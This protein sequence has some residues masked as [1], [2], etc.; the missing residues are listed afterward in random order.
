MWNSNLVP[1]DRVRVIM[2]GILL[3]PVSH[4]SMG[5]YHQ[6]GHPLYVAA[7]QMVHRA[8]FPRSHIILWLEH[9]LHVKKNDLA[10]LMFDWI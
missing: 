10:A 3:P 8:N 6:F 4:L 5:A 7:R 9:Q 1:L 2:V